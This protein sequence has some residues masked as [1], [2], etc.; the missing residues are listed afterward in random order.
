MCGYNFET[1]YVNETTVSS[2]KV[3]DTDFCEATYEPLCSESRRSSGCDS[4]T[5]SWDGTFNVVADNLGEYCDTTT[6]CCISGSV[7][8]VTESATSLRIKAKLSGTCAATEIDQSFPVSFWGNIVLVIPSF[9]VRK[10]LC[11]FV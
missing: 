6:C 8:F 5:G 11:L 3:C 4:V 1:A 10:L 2:C 7:T 9:I